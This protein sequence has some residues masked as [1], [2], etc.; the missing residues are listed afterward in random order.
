MKQ[1]IC[2]LV[3]CLLAL[4]VSSILSQ[5]SASNNPSFTSYKIQQTPLAPMQTEGVTINGGEIIAIPLS[6]NKS[7]HLIISA[8]QCEGA[9]T[10]F[11]VVSSPDIFNAE[12]P[13]VQW[14]PIGNS[15][16]T[17]SVK[18]E[19][20]SESQGKVYL[21]VKLVRALSDE[22]SYS[23][24]R[25]IL[26][27]SSHSPEKVFSVPTNSEIKWN[28]D[29]SNKL[30]GS[31]PVLDTNSALFDELLDETSKSETLL[32]TYHLIATTSE[33]ITEGMAKCNMKVKGSTGLVEAVQEVN[34]PDTRSAITFE[35]QPTEKMYYMAV[36]AT[37]SKVHWK[38]NS[39]KSWEVQYLYPVS[40]YVVPAQPP[41]EQLKE[42][43]KP[44]INET[45]NKTSQ[46]IPVVP[47]E[48]NQTSQQNTSK[49]TVEPIPMTKG[50]V[51]AAPNKTEAHSML[52]TSQQ[53]QPAS[54]NITVNGDH[55]NK[56]E[57]P[58]V[59]STE[60]KANN[61]VVSGSGANVSESNQIIE[62]NATVQQPST[63]NTSANQSAV[64]TTAS[65][66]EASKEKSADKTTEKEKSQ[67]S[68]SKNI[69]LI[70]AVVVILLFVLGKMRQSR[71]EQKR[72]HMQKNKNR[73]SDYFEQSST[74]YELSSKKNRV[75]V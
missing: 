61:T 29:A 45:V 31:L 41:K 16:L 3:L 44:V 59:N 25:T 56:T 63:N 48:I 47:L 2:A 24:F 1:K 13:L 15:I 68:S 5:E 51:D 73:D 34:L 18:V 40:K 58:V 39:R 57:E 54:S 30:I 28:W 23:E 36:V 49:V 53:Q 55:T 20:G 19:T 60:V 38:D 21:L 35:I 67:S 32:V 46:E 26:A 75:H 74:Y 4:Q 72:Q 66:K 11:S 52:N 27:T 14:T 69:V 22:S 8:H 37:V 7:G 64:N 71:S 70:V 12:K 65:A 50:D 43:E 62:G 9:P 42:N 33:K 6:Y 10:S 17:T